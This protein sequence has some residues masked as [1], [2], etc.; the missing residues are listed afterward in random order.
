MAFVNE[1]VAEEDNKKYAVDELLAEFNRFNWRHGRP[2]GFSPAW[3]IDRERDIYL[4]LVKSIEEV[5]PSGRPE[6]T[7]KANWI[8]SW[9]GRRAQF[10]IERVWA[11]GSTDFADSPFRVVWSLKWS[12]TSEVPDVPREQLVACLKEA[13]TAYGHSGVKGQVANT[14]V[15]FNF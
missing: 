6:P 15:S 10:T 13:L 4:I 12:D 11:A 7:G 1:F 3:T 5:G 8:L 2:P 9:Q 14:T